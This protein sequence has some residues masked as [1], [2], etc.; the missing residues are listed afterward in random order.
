MLKRFAFTLYYVYCFFCKNPKQPTPIHNILADAVE[1]CSGSRHL[2]KILNRLGCT[3]SSD[4]H[5]RFVTQHAESRWCKDV[6]DELNS[7]VFTIA[8]VD[9][10]DILKSHSAV[11]CGDQNR[12]YHGTTLQLVQPDPSLIYH[13]IAME[14]NVMTPQ[15]A[16]EDTP[17]PLTYTQH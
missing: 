1:V 3:R 14:D 13:P 16:I 10:F 12:S 4:T 17:Q 15:P 2:L 5:D 9:N 11:Y 7:N 6:W 8:S